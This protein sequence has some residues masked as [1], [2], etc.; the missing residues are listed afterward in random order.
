MKNKITLIK[1]SNT[2][3]FP[4]NDFW[5]V[6]VLIG[7]NWYVHNHTF[8]NLKDAWNFECDVQDRGKI[9]LKYWAPLN[10]DQ[11]KKV[12]SDIAYCNATT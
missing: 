6:I 7:K 4:F 11:L 3:T 8:D 9:N 2:N 12:E 10:S 1:P 5:N